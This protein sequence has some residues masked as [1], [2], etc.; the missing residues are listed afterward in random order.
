MRHAICYVSTSNRNLNYQQTEE[1]LNFCQAQ[2]KLLGIK[3]V[4]LYSEGNFFQILEGKKEVVLSLFEKIKKDS[5]HRGIIQV[6]GRDVI[7]DRHDGYK[8][9]TVKEED[10]YRTD[11][12]E[13]YSE[14]L[15]GMPMGIKKIME[16][17]LQNFLATR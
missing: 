5:L 8:I 11:L 1:L 14:T 6:V 2:N 13:D 17:M 16:G 10:S 15:E 7:P 12:P 3:S 9:D 4:L